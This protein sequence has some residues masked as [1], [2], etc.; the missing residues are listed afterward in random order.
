[1][2]AFQFEPGLPSPVATKCPDRRPRATH[3]VEASP[4]TV[5]DETGNGYQL[6]VRAATL[7]N[8]RSPSSKS[9]MTAS[10]EAAAHSW[11]PRSGLFGQTASTSIGS[12]AALHAASDDAK[13]N[14]CKPRRGFLMV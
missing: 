14:S 6:P 12:T 4:A 3:F 1:M 13:A 8:D 7:I 11:G 5:V 10:G 9:S 2:L